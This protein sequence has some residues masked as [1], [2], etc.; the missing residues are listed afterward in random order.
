MFS[1]KQVVLSEYDFALVEDVNLLATPGL[2]PIVA[3]VRLLQ[4]AGYYGSVDLQYG[5]LSPVGTLE[6]YRNRGLIRKLIL[7][8]IHPAA[9]ERGD[10][11]LFILGIPHFYRQFGYEYAVPHKT[12]RILKDPTACF[13]LDLPSNNT[14]AQE[15]EP[16][17]L[18]E[19]TIA[20]IRY[21][22]KL[23]TPKQLCANA[24]LGTYYD[25][26][27]W[28]FVIEAFSPIRTQNFHDVHHHACVVVDTETKK[29]VGISLTSH[30]CG[31]WTW[32]VFTLDQDQ[33]DSDPRAVL[34][35]RH[36]IPSV[37]RQLKSMDRTFYECYNIKL[38][39]GVL[40]EE[41]DLEKRQRG[42]F[43]PLQ[44]STLLVGLTPTHPATR[45]LDSQGKLDPAQ[46]G[47]R[48][49]TRIGSLP[50]FVQT[51]APTLEVRLQT[52]AMRGTSARLQINFYRKLEGM[53]GRGL[54]IVFQNGRLVRASDWVAK[55]AEQEFY[56]LRESKKQIESQQGVN[57]KVDS[58]VQMTLK[59]SFAPLTFTRLIT[60]TL[61]VNELLKR[62]SE[63]Y[64]EGGEARLLLEILF[65]KTDH[66]VDLCWF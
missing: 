9:D 29:D 35:S 44:F 52:S 26:A 10:V 31:R 21:F 6:K 45:L 7:E 8:M 57:D 50:K 37:L 59:A 47:Y 46:D 11:L 22:V 18:R 63:N 53:S 66:Y 48:M 43:P 20:D 56:E 41:F 36:V 16:Y 4:F 19:A 24:N 30:V 1:D 38:N 3:A 39:G 49:Y 2:N 65:L 13:P 40:P 27:F 55:T 15:A 61:D 42:Q 25:Y 17:M 64:V 33:D 32:E 54:E 62:D 58:N 60:G 5:V 28:E 23:S 34:T 51:V 12:G 14:G